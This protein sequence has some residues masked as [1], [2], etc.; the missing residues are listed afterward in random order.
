MKNTQKQFRWNPERKAIVETREIAIDAKDITEVKQ[1]LRAELFTII[2]Q[3]K[4][5]KARAE[6]IKEILA[7]IEGAG[8][9]PP[10]P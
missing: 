3:V 5:L 1:K 6:E 4:T 7:Q 10:A 9:I 8:V 2:R